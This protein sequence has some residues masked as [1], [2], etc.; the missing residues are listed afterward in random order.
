M[1]LW[2]A[3][4]VVA[5]YLCAFWLVH[6]FSLLLTSIAGAI[7]FARGPRRQHAK[8]AHAARDAELAEQAHH[9][10]S[11]DEVPGTNRA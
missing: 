9:A 8:A 4:L 11:R 7:A 3:V 10:A 6:G 1:V 2:L 5:L